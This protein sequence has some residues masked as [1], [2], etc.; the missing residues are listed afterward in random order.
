M[1]VQSTAA[2]AAAAAANN[3]RVSSSAKTSADIPIFTI[4]GDAKRAR[5]TIVIKNTAD[6][7]PVSAMESMTGKI[8]MPEPSYSV[9]DE[10]AEYF[11]EK[12]G[13]IYDE[14]AVGKLYCELAEKG[15]ISVN[16]VS[17]A[18]G[19]VVMIPLS[20]VKSITFFG[21]G[22]DY[23]LIERWNK[24]RGS[25]TGET[26]EK[27]YIKDICRTSS[28]DN[29][30]RREWEDFKAKCD[31]EIV[32]W[33]DALEE[34]IEFERYLKEAAKKSLD[35]KHY[36]DQWHFDNVLENLEKTKE[37]IFKIFGE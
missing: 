15:I 28:D 34:S 5:D 25:C 8:S 23:G 27:V 37:V 19:T 6:V 18:S 9:T 3:H 17:R 16:D 30:Y 13:D 10:E 14:S 22:S 11:C 1:N 2:A 36:P 31:L 20:A 35:G 26:G 12:Y 29:P 21:T 24:E 4:P 32:S 33:K 7:D